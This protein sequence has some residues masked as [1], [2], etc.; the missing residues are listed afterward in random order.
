MALQ[1]GDLL[2]VYRET[3]QKNYK[4]TVAQLFSRV[5]APVAKH[6]HHHIGTIA[7]ILSSYIQLQKSFANTWQLFV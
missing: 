2:A 1:D 4:P 7:R 5:P 6:K 3:D